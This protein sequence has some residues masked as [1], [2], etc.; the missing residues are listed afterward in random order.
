MECSDRLYSLLSTVG[1][2]KD[3]NVLHL[4]GTHLIDLYNLPY[5]PYHNISHI[6]HCLKELDSYDKNRA[7]ELAIFYHDAIYDPKAKNNE[8]MCANRAAYDLCVMQVPKKIIEKIQRLIIVTK[9]STYPNE[10]YQDKLIVDVDLSILGQDEKT[11]R[12]YYI[13]IREEY[14]HVS[15]Y[16]YAKGR[17]AFLKK[18]LERPTIYQ[19]DFF[20]RKYEQ[21]ARDNIELE[22]KKMHAIKLRDQM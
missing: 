13:E 15:D 17:I 20:I 22:L 7:V 11:Y 1:S 9:H 10:L 14:S 2:N 5:R 18:L 19:M 6:E 21:A 12:R 16:G 3:S 4:I 8:E